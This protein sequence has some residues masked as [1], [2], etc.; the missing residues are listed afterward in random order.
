MEDVKLLKYKVLSSCV[1]I[2]QSVQKLG[3][4][5]DNRVIGV[6]LPARPRDFSFL[7]S[8]QRRVWTP[9]NLLSGGYQGLV[10][11]EINRPG[12]EADHFSVILIHRAASHS[13]LYIHGDVL[14]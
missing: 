3:Y 7:H 13:P 8:V 2:A 6:R 4:G 5:L 9:K 10:P 1:G 11:P 12:H 14:N